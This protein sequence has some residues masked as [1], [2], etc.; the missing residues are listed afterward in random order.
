[1]AKRRPSNPTAARSTRRSGWIAIGLLTLGVVLAYANALSGEFVF[2]DR[3]SIAENPTIR[4]LWPPEPVLSPP[5][6]AGVG[7]RPVANLTLAFNYALGGETMT[8]YRVGNIMIHGLAALALL[9]LVRRT[10]LLPSLREK[11]GAAAEWL[12]L[13]IAGLWALHPVQSI[14]VN[15]ISQRTESLMGLFY[16]LTLYCLVRGAAGG[17]RWWHP[18]AIVACALGMASKEVMVTAPVMALLYDRT[19]VAGSFA[20]AWR[21]R[22]KVYGGLAT[23]WVLLAFL[24]G[25]LRT[26]GVGFGF[27]LGWWDYAG[28]GAYAIFTY[29]RLALFPCPLIFDYGPNVV[30]HLAAWPYFVAVLGLAALTGFSLWRRPVAGF[31]GA[32]FLVILAPTST[33]VPIVRQMVA[34]NRMYAPLAGVAALV[35]TGLYA[36]WGRR[37]LPVLGVLALGL[38]A[39]TSVRNQTYRTALEL[40]ADTVA[41]QPDNWRARNILAEILAGRGQLDASIDHYRASVKIDPKLAETRNNLGAAL[42]RAGRLPEAIAEYEAALQIE[43]GRAGTHTNLGNVLCRV[44]R[45]AEGVAHFEEALR[46][47]P[48]QADLQANFGA[49]LAQ[50]GRRDEAIARFERALQLEPKAAGVH[51]PLANALVGAGRFVDAVF[52]YE[53][54]LKLDPGAAEAANNLGVVLVQLGRRSEARTYFEKAVRVKPGYIDARLNLAGVLADDG[55]PTEARMHYEAVL[56]LDSANAQAQAGLAKL[57]A[58]R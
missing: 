27:D 43:P 51:Y 19:F 47:A 12:A 44:G 40:W 58:P 25:G 4:Q 31:F 56:K 24:M 6:T 52:H 20:A 39:I 34:E 48:E 50:L 5:A 16:F 53:A 13:A 10:F 22:W 33:V 45:S 57:P 46:L 17:A 30:D 9:G 15:Y 49:V 26:R 29:L 7:G 41:K 35:A 23:T 55:F 1:M 28:G 32:W 54:A 38:G 42:E 8:G 18:L 14:D 11:F 3:T 36:K 37:V 21:A 2:D